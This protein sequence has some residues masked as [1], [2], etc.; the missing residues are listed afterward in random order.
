MMYGEEQNFHI[1]QCFFRV[2]K[3]NMKKY[4]NNNKKEGF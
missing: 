3:N 1:F 2:H 4:N